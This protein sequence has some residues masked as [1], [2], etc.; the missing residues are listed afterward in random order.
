MLVSSGLFQTVLQ[1]GKSAFVILEPD[2][3]IGGAHIAFLPFRSR[4]NGFCESRE[5]PFVIQLFNTEISLLQLFII[6]S[7]RIRRFF[8]CLPLCFS[9]FS[10]EFSICLFLSRVLLPRAFFS[11]AAQKQI[12]QRC[13]K[14][15]S[16]NSSQNRDK[17]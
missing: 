10:G 16:Q 12:S 8:G 2:I 4:L 13:Q 1:N 14:Q 3:S 7:V 17:F 5:S 6:Q 11:A 9:R 15:K